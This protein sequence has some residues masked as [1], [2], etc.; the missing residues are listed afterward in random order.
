VKVASS[1]PGGELSD[2]W[3]RRN[4]IISGW[5]LYSAVYVGFAFASS[6]WQIWLL[7]AT[8]GLFAGLTEGAERALVIDL[9][10]EEWRGRAL[11]AY[12]A[13]VG[14]ALL[15]ASLVFGTIY[16][17]IGA[18]PA[19]TLGAMLALAAVFILPRARAG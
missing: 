12:Q 10:P 8:Y 5:L 6:T 3:G 4:T 14:I 18:T 15:P 1:T 16:Q 11:G 9:V 19:F 2:Q 13:T 7:F 17:H